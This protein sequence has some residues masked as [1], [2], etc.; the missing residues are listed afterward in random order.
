MTP[1][2]VDAKMAIWFNEEMDTL[3]SV[4]NNAKFQKLA[5][6]MGKA[7]NISMDDI[8]SNPNGFFVTAYYKVREFENENNVEIIKNFIA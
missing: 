3:L 2:Q 4:T 8:R 5:L 1:E 6:E 7:A